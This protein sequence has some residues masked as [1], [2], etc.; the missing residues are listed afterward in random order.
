MWFQIIPVFGPHKK[1]SK[2]GRND[3]ISKVRAQKHLNVAFVSF[4]HYDVILLFKRKSNMCFQ[5]RSKT[6]VSH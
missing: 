5:T 6:L 4:F 3:A 1:S 2:L